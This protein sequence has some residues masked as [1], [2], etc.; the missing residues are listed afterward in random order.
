MLISSDRAELLFGQPEVLVKAAHLVNDGSIRVQAD[1]AEVTYVHLLF[2][3]HE[4]VTGN[5]LESE[6]YHPGRETIDS[7]DEATRA[8]IMDLMDGAD[9]AQGYGPAA[10]PSLRAHEARV[11][12]QH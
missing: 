9:A 8:E 11:L 3:R 1:G 6:S 5:G 10:R 2:D 4:I 12:L 7:F